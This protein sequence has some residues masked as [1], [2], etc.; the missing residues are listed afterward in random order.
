VAFWKLAN[1]FIWLSCLHPNLASYTVRYA[2]NY[3]LLPPN[4]KKRGRAHSV[5]QNPCFVIASRAL[6]STKL[7][8]AARVSLTHILSPIEDHYAERMIA[9]RGEQDGIALVE[10]R[11][12]HEVIKAYRPAY[13]FIKDDPE[14][15][16]GFA[17]AA[18]LYGILSTPGKEALSIVSDDMSEGV[19]IVLAWRVHLLRDI[20]SKS[21]VPA[22]LNNATIRESV[23]YL[24]N[25]PVADH[26]Q[27]NITTVWGTLEPGIAVRIIQLQFILLINAMKHYFKQYTLSLSN[28]GRPV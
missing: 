27:G 19:A 1:Y 9:L 17:R 6:P 11:L 7:V 15:G 2:S 18:I 21:L 13:R 10:E 28:G 16:A 12:G 24:W 23:Q 5:V 8:S 3:R 20:F 14:L 25:Y 26:V 4:V 22:H